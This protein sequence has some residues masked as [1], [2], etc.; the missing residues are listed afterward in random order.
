MN[1][2][3]NPFFALTMQARKQHL[4]QQLSD[5]A[6]KARR[7][8]EG[9]DTSGRYEDFVQRR[10][11]RAILT[12]VSEKNLACHVFQ[13]KKVEFCL[14]QRQQNFH[15]FAGSYDYIKYQ[16]RNIFFLTVYQVLPRWSRLHPRP[17]QLASR[18]EGPERPRGPL[19]QAQVVGI[20]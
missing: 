2:E 1:M 16:L 4:C 7:M 12:Q 19:G 14:P 18:P 11:L 5:P 13:R 9:S 8:S 3:V 6:D 20:P 17:A 10:Y 15:Q